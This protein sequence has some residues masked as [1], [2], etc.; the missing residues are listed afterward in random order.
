MHDS[1]RYEEAAQRIE[2]LNMFRQTMITTFDRLC[3]P[4]AS[5]MAISQSFYRFAVGAI[6]EII[7]EIYFHEIES[8][9]KTVND[10]KISLS[11]Y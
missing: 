5:G 8:A 1:R 9:L 2:Y 4:K 7:Q 11:I 10:H 6:D 3:E